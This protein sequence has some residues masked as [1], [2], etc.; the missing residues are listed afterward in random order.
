M[1]DVD[2]EVLHHPHVH[3]LSVTYDRKMVAVGRGKG[4]A[5]PDTLAQR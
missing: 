4:V 5:G 1:G 3:D 2:L